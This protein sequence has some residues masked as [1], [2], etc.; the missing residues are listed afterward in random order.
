MEG[1]GNIYERAWALVKTAYNSAAKHITELM[2][3]GITTVEDIENLTQQLNKLYGYANQSIDIDS[4]RASLDKLTL[5]I[6]SLATVLF[7]M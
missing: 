4:D 6:N 7:Q 2:A 3:K 5:N 1:K